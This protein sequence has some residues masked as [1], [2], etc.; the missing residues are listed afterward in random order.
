MRRSRFPMFAVAAC[1]LPTLAFAQQS[2]FRISKVD[3]AFQESPSFQGGYMKKVQRPGK[4]LEVEMT[5][6]WTARNP[7]VKYLDDLTASYY[8]LLKNKT[9]E[10]PQGQLLTGTVQHVSVAPGRD[11][12]SVMYLPPRSLERLFEGKAPNTAQA[13]IAGVGVTLSQGGTVVAEFTTSGKGRWWEQMQG[14]PGLL[15]PKTETPFAALA[16]DYYEPVKGRTSG[17]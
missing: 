15:L 16:W 6:D 3:T 5:F 13:A 2:D 9:K 7:E 14:T 1:L 11:L 12:H 8:V 17:Q 4:W 10:F